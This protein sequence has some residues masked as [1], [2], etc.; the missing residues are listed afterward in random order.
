MKVLCLVALLASAAPAF[1]TDTIPPDPPQAVQAE[2][3]PHYITLTWTASPSPDVA[4]Y[5]VYRESGCDVL[6][7]CEPVLMGTRAPLDES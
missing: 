3:V 5:R 2:Y 4:Q 7:G 6:P 1:A